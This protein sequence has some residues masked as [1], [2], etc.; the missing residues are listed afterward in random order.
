MKDSHLS[1]RLSEEMAD[2]L[3]RAAD[4]GSVARSQLVREAVVQYLAST[5]PPAAAHGVSSRELAR[6]W[7]S[8]PRLT[9]AEATEFANEI[10]ADRAALP[11]VEAEW[12]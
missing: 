10:E 11:P 9:P 2:L 6:R 1:V 8:L 4:A 12:D 3:A 7:A 5:S